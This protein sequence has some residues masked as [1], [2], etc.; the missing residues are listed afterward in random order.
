MCFSCIAGCIGIEIGSF[1]H[2]LWPEDGGK[3]VRVKDRDLVRIDAHVRPIAL[4][5]PPD[6]QVLLPAQYDSR[7]VELRQPRPERPR[8]ARERVEGRQAVEAD[9]REEC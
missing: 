3:R 5:Q 2:P 8:E 4:M 1:G 6:V 9:R 7:V